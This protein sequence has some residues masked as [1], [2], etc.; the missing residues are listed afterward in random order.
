MLFG[1]VLLMIACVNPGNV[2]AQQKVDDKELIGVWAMESMQ[3][4]G[5]EKVMT[6]GNYSRVKVYC[7]NGEY[8]CA[9]IAKLNNGEYKVLPHEYGTYT[10]KDGKY[11]E[12]G[13]D[14]I[15]I[16]IDNNTFKGRWMNCHEIWKKKANVPTEL[17]NYLVEKC[18]E[19]PNAPEKIQ[20][21]IKECFFK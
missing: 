6:G 5:E 9:E 10:F 8:A 4:E 7:A 20:L 12:L 3:F 2:M 1:V 17:V 14:G 19:K 21:Q 18:K 13:R 11:T 16:M 15:V